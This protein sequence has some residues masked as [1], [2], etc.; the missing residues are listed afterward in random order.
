MRRR[1]PTV[2]DPPVDS[3]PARA[4]YDWAR[5]GRHRLRTA[6]TVLLDHPLGP[7]GWTATTWSDPTQPGGRNWLG[8]QPSPVGGWT[9]PIRLALGDV[10]EFGNGEAHWFGIVDSYDPDG[11]LT[12]RG[13]YPNRATAAEDAEL[14]LA[15]ERYLPAVESPPVLRRSCTRRRQRPSRHP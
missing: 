11:W 10:I 15:A 1:H 8:W 12:L 14:L 4:A 6:A 3:S 7:G 9:L 13:P 5:F 2:P